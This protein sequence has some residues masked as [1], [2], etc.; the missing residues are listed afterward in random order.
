MRAFFQSF[1]YYKKHIVMLLNK[2]TVKIIKKV[3]KFTKKSKKIFKS[4]LINVLF[5]DIIILS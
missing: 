4:P 1:I 5:N 2:K 3:F